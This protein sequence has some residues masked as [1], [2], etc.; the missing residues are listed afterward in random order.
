M[1]KLNYEISNIGDEIM[2]TDS[3]I[4]LTIGYFY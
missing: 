1:V 3:I 2:T 4:Q